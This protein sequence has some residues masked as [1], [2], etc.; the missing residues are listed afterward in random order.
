MTS[1]SDV[2]CRNSD[3]VSV[4]LQRVHARLGGLGVDITTYGD[5]AVEI[6]WRRDYGT[7][8]LSDER[9]VAVTNLMDGL[10]EILTY[11]DGAD[12]ADEAQ[13]F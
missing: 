10:R 6:R 8:C 13:S 4:L 12:V 1:P 5:N 2:H 9:F 7:G 11:E 3:D